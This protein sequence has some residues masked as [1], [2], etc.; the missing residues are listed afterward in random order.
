MKSVNNLGERF[1]RFLGAAVLA[2]VFS[3]TSFAAHP[4]ITDDTGTQGKGKMQVE[5]NY[6][7]DHEDT[8]GVKENLHQ[9]ETV[10]SY[11]I[12]DSVDVVVGLPYQLLRTEEAGVKLKEDGIS[13]MSIELK[14]RFFE[15]EGLSLAVKPGLTIPTGDDEKGL[16]AGKVG[17]SF[18]FIATQEFEPWTFHF[19]AGYGR[20]ESTV[21]E[22]RDIWHVSLASEVTVCKWLKVVGNIGAERSPDKGAST[23]AAFLLGGFIFPVTDFMDLDIGVKGGLTEAESD[24][25]ILAGV[26]FRF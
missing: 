10:V 16:G 21:D 3:G 9:L 25:A 23:P 11:G 5:I 12:V 19:N 13:D 26:A 1:T 6:E 2:L 24:Y 20:N 22:E 8:G 15:R 14:W 7:F 17:G 18:F 4:L